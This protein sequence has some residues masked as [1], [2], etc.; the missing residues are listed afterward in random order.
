[1]REFVIGRLPLAIGTAWVTIEDWVKAVNRKMQNATASSGVRVRIN[2]AL[3]K[4]LNAAEL[5]VHRLACKGSVLTADEQAEVG[6]ALQALIAGADGATMTEKLTNAVDV[7]Q[8][9]DI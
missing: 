8:W 3:A 6:E 1:L 2:K 5:T 4:D 7:R 9:L